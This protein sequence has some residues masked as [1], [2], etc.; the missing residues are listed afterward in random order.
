MSRPSFIK[1]SEFIIFK[2]THSE[3]KRTILNLKGCRDSSLF[4]DSGTFDVGDRFAEDLSVKN[5]GPGVGGRVKV[6]TKTVCMYNVEYL[7]K[8]LG[9]GS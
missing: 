6:A 4:D 8:S 7:I 5:R 3:T 1:A 9:D 2:S